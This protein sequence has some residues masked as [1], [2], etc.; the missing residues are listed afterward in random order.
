MDSKSIIKDALNLSP[1]ERIL[2]LEALSKSLSE[3]DKEI[4]EI[5]KEEVEQRYKAYIDGKIKTISYDEIIK[6]Q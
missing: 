4:D 2:I 3:P 1:A 6:K 5:W